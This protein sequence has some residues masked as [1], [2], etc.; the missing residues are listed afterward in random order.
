MCWVNSYKAN[1]RHST[2]QKYNDNKN[3]NNKKYNN[4]RQYVK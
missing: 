4:S 2:A 3:N 1:Y